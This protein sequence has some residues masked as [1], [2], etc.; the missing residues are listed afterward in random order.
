MPSG[1]PV[2]SF[3][4]PATTVVSTT[5]AVNTGVTLTI[6]A[7]AGL[8]N[9]LVLLEITLFFV[10]VPTPGSSPQLVTSTGITGT[11]TFSFSLPAAAI[12]TVENRIYSFPSP[13]KGSAVNTAMTIVCPAQANSIWRVNGYYFTDV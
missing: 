6:P 9:Y 4:N 11:P 7:T 13:L 2:L 12:G 1:Q 8:F 3:I 5:A 10:T